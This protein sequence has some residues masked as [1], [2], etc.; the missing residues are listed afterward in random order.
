SGR[1]APCATGA[2]IAGPVHAQHDG[3]AAGQDPMVRGDGKSGGADFQRHRSHGRVRGP[4]RALSA[5][6]RARAPSRY[7]QLTTFASLRRWTRARRGRSVEERDNASRN[8]VDKQISLR[9]WEEHMKRLT[10]MVS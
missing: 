7:I 9:A 6:A 3:H 5:V 4:S 8:I 1:G 2:I 10:V